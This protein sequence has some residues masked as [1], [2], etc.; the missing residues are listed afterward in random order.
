MALAPRR[1]LQEKGAG[2]ATVSVSTTSQAYT[3]TG[4]MGVFLSGSFP[5]NYVQTPSGTLAFSGSTACGEQY[6]TLQLNDVNG[7]PMPQ[8]APP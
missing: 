8:L 3:L 5:T 7:N 6:F 2:L 4:A 1:C